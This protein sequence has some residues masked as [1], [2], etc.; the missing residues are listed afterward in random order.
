[1]FEVNQTVWV[2]IP[3]E[4]ITSGTIVDLF[5]ENSSGYTVRCITGGDVTLDASMIYSTYAE[6]KDDLVRTINREIGYLMMRV[7]SL[8]TAIRK[9]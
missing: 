4:K 8:K 5:P 6:A 2:I 7:D 3:G 9:L 1:M